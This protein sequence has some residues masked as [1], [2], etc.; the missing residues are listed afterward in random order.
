MAMTSIFRVSLPVRSSLVDHGIEAVVVGAQGLEDLPDDFV[1]LVVVEGFVRLHA[2]GDDDGQDDVAAF[3]LPS[4]AFAHD[5]ADGLDDID[6]GIARSEE[7][8]GIE[9]RDIHAFGEAA[10]VAEDAA[11]VRPA[12]SALSQ[13]SFS[14]FWL[15]FMVPSTW[16]ASQR[17]VL[18]ESS[19]A[20]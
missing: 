14:S 10:D 13:S 11:G 15:A 1:N 20:W 8:H 12:A 4:G 19:C 9:R 2:R 17:R 3:F 18:S 5:A 7:E 6:L 16:S